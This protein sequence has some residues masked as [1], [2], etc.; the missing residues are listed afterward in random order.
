LLGVVWLGLVFGGMAIAF[1]PS[2]HSRMVGWVL[3]V[4]AAVVLV[5][6]MDWWV[7]AFPGLLILATLNG[8]ITVYTGHLIN[9]TSI[10]IP[11][12]EAI[13]ITLFFGASGFLCARFRTGV[14]NVIDRAALF[15]FMFC[16]FWQAAAPRFAGVAGGVAFCALLLAWTYGRVR[17]GA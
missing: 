15:T 16:L 17:A 10:P 12:S 11:R 14:L 9:N 7:K 13:I 6:T 3:L 5:A 4:L 8:I 2:P 1:S